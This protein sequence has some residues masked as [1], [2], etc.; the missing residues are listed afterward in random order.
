MVTAKQLRQLIP[1]G[2]MY[3]LRPDCRYIVQ[4]PEH[5]PMNVVEIV[6]KQLT[7]AKVNAL[8][9]VGDE[10]KFFDLGPINEQK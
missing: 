4:L 5:M 1:V 3:E 9:M 7:D 10:I 6:Y 2:E 8:L